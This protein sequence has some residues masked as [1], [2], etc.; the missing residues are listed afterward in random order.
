MVEGAGLLG[1][2]KNILAALVFDLDEAFLDID[3]GRA[4]FAHGAELHQVAAGR[5]LAHR[6]EDVQR[7]RHVVHL[8][9]NGAALVDHGVGRGGL[10]AVMDNGLRA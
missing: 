9:Q 8:G 1:E 3:V 4:V 6:P 5:E 10:L 7:S 2:G